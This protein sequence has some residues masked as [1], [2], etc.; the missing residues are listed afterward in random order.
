[1]TPKGGRAIFGACRPPGNLQADATQPESQA[2]FRQ[3]GFDGES[4]VGGGLGG[5][6]NARAVGFAKL[7]L[8]DRLPT[9]VSALDG[10]QVRPEQAAIDIGT[11]VEPLADV[12]FGG[13]LLGQPFDLLQRDDLG[14][15]VLRDGLFRGWERATTADFRG[16]V[17]IA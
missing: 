15:R 14:E 5:C 9:D 17:T 12:A 10:F 3:L 7:P 6:E 11:G 13:Q 2:A 16:S 1:M 4:G 8:A